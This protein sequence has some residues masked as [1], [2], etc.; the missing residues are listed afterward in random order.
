MA[1][2]E[3]GTAEHGK[4]SG[5]RFFSQKRRWREGR[6]KKGES[7]IC[8]ELTVTQS[9]LSLTRAREMERAK[10]GKVCKTLH[11]GG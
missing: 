5:M 1:A 10:E 11:S 2:K 6:K 8:E 3:T 4:G 9:K 7:A